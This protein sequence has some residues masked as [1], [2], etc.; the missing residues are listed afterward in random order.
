MA[1]GFPVPFVHAN[2]TSMGYASFVQGTL[3]TSGASAN[4]KGSWTQLSSSTAADF[5][6]LYLS[7]NGLAS[8]AGRSIAF[9]L[10]AAP[11]GSE[12]SGLIVQNVIYELSTQIIWNMIIPCGQLAAGTRIAIRMASVTASDETNVGLIGL[13]AGWLSQGSGAGIDTYGYSGSGAIQGITVD[14]GGTASTKGAYTQLTASTTND[15]CGFFLTFDNLSSDPAAADATCLV[16]VALGAA[17]SEKI[18]LPNVAVSR[19]FFGVGNG[20]QIAPNHTDIF[21]IPIK[22]GTRI[23]VRASCAIN[24]ATDRLLG[25]ALY[26]VRR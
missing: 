19:N 5:T 15:Y 1:G 11:G 13:D 4:T 14:P 22:A 3:V 23:A 25:V 9:D 17:G 26:G 7:L 8:H 6:H 21:Y 10:A 16:D 20:Y 24:T 12:A 2:A 18:I